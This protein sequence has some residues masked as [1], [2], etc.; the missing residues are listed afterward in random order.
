MEVITM[1]SEAWK[2][3][4]ADIEEAKKL[5][6]AMFDKMN[7]TAQDRWFSPKDAAEYTGFNI[8]WIKARSAKIGAFQDGKGL[9]FKKSNVDKYMEKNSFKA[10]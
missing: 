10:K 5:T 2:A 1:E 6:K 7:D 4:I 3:L 8:A 9:R